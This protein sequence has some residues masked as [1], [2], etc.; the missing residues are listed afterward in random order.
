MIFSK[1]H[2][3]RC[4]EKAELAGLAFLLSGLWKAMSGICEFGD[5]GI[6]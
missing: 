5:L 6:R 2:Q 1:I 3:V 4:F